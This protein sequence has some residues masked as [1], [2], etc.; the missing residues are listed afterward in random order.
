MSEQPKNVRGCRSVPQFTDTAWLEVGMD[1]AK[2]GQPVPL[3]DSEIS[4]SYEQPAMKPETATGDPVP[5]PFTGA[6]KLLLGMDRFS[7]LSSEMIALLSSLYQEI[8]KSAEELHAARSAV[9]L[10]RKE[11]E[12]LREAEISAIAL[13][14]QIEEIKQQKESLEGLIIVQRNEWEAEKAR[15]AREEKEYYENRQT[16]REREDEEYKRAWTAERL[17]AQQSLEEELNAVRQRSLEAQEAA[18]RNFFNRDL[19]LKKKEQEWGQLIQEL[20]QFLS[21]LA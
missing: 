21:K 9:E 10:E 11:I 13:Q 14:Q 15:R 3:Q 8:N 17:K 19:V 20:E 5:Q 16:L 18:E 2:D 1:E 4:K 6:E 7:G 12:S